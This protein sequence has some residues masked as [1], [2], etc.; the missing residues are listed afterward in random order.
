M[1]SNSSF[2]NTASC[3]GTS[4]QVLGAE[5]KNAFLVAMG[6]RIKVLR[7]RQRMT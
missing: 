1:S 3:Q 4:A 6:N 7:A 5:E 2:S